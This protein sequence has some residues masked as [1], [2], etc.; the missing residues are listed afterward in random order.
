MFFW[1]IFIPVVTILVV[2]FFSNLNLLFGKKLERFRLPKHSPQR[3][4]T[5]ERKNVG[6][7]LIVFSSMGFILD[8][9]IERGLISFQTVHEWNIW[10]I[11]YLFISF[12]LALFIH[13]VYFY[14]T[15]RFLH[16]PFVFKRIHRIHH[17]S[18]KVNAWSSFSFH[19]FEGLIQIGIVILVPMFIPI[20]I[21]VQIVFVF[22]LI[23]MSVY[24]HAGYE[25]R[26]NK[27]AIFSIFNTA[28]HHTQHHE[29]VRYNFGI[30]LNLWDKIFNTN[31][32]N[33]E[34][35]FQDLAAKIKHS[36]VEK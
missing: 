11:S 20:H 25:L 15:H 31:H 17:Q 6:F 1:T 7:N 14:L 13:D 35:Y 22:F 24:G 26:A 28:V 12:F 23:F 4:S 3:I 36:K 32:P 8:R 30:Y 19:P 5:V 16:I 9:S 33:Y 10:S 29:S 18:H 2:L 21:G 34:K 27:K